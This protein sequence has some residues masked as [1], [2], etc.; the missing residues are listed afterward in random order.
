[1][2]KKR[3]IT[4]LMYVCLVFGGIIFL[5]PYVY[6]LIASTQNNGM[7]L[8]KT[9]NLNI[10]GFFGDN[11]K[12]LLDNY[13]YIKVVWNSLFV[14]V[15]GTLVSTFVTTLAGY[16]LAKYRFLGN[17]FIF[18]LIMLS[19]MIPGFAVLIP[20]FLLFSKFGLTNSY[21]GVILP[22]VA[23]ANAV[24]IMKQYADSFPYELI[25]AARIDSASEWT[26]F[27]RI[28]VPLLKP[29]I[30]TSALLIFMGYWNS[31][32]FPLVMISDSE[33]YTVPLVIRNITQASQDDL[34][35]GAMMTALATSVI[36]VII[37]YTW[38]QSKFKQTNA[39]VGI[40]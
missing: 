13:Q 37:L 40:K 38:V 12:Y 20:T 4:V 3:L 19:R 14:T 21:A 11:I 5:V 9:L 15:I 25:E 16:T 8:S 31:Y 7:I 22:L 30:I 36:P 32:L 33:M 35:Y 27:Y 39:S 2:N 1:M 18:S 10:G 24:F 34:N 6:M 17:K 28:A 23:S 26:I 29:N